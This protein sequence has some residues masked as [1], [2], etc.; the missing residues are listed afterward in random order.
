M[1]LDLQKPLRLKIRGKLVVAFAGLSILPVLIVGLLAISYNVS[2]LRRIAVENLTDDLLTIK[3]RLGAFFGEMEDNGHF[4][5]ASASFRRFLQTTARHP[6]AARSVADLELLQELRAF[7][8]RKGILYQIKFIDPTGVEV[9]NIEK[10]SGEYYV[11][12]RD[13]LNRTGTRFYLYL[14]GRIPPNRATFVPVELWNVQ[15]SSS[16]PA[17]S[18]VYPVYDPEFSGVLI[19]QIYAKRFFKI[20][21]QKTPHISAGTVMLV[22]AEGYYLYHSEK[23]KEWNHLLASKATENLKHDFGPELTNRLLNPNSALLLESSRAMI[24]HVPL[25]TTAG[26]TGSQYILLKSVPKE[27]IF[28]PV[29]KFKR[30]FWGLLGLFLLVSLA[31]AYL[32]TRQF[33]DPIQKLQREIEEVARGDFHARVDIRTHDEIQELARQFNFMAQSLEQRE[34]ELAQHRER[35]EQMVQERTR[36]LRDQKNKLQVILDNVPSGFLL[37]DRD[38]RI[39]SA[40]AA[41]SSITGTPVEDLLGRRCYEVM[42]NMETCAS[43]PSARVFESGRMET[44]LVRRIGAEGEERYLEHVAVPLKTD[45]RV[46]TVLEI[47]TDVTERKR[48]QDQLIR[49][50]RLAATGE[51]AA[52]IAHEMRNSLTSVQMIL[53]LLAETEGLE[54]S[55]RESLGVALDSIDRM[56]RV[57]DDLLQLA[58]PA[59]LDKKPANIND[60]LTDSVEFARHQVAR[61]GIELEMQFDEHVPLIPLDRDHMKEAVFN[62]LL[63]A[64]QAIRERG[65]I[66]VRSSLHTLTKQLRHLGEVG[67]AADTEGV[68]VQEIILKKGTRVLRVEV[69]DT[70]CGIPEE[71][72]ARIFDPFFT[73]KTNGTGLGLSFVKRVVN[74]HGG[75]VRVKSRV[76]KGSTFTLLLPLYDSRAGTSDRS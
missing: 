46:S 39:L 53:Q 24:A 73:T 13:E 71:H 10:R 18:C 5:T 6:S 16:L 59:P 19:L 35:L 70:G 29:T 56:E 69:A 14:A 32:A 57:V 44:Q 30:V 67:M 76:G 41:L 60:I 68:A 52:V 37:L 22:N 26:T 64:S 9:F 66:V 45:G 27:A 11:L 51:I 49:S 28:A 17:I 63:N 3:E 74:E 38:H 4:I 48:L 34:A 7:A 25:F 65:K 15:T 1:G 43:C 33:T 55:D 47:I 62:L 61:S 21:E 72:M 20:I 12:S 8:R 75:V 40:S 36:E 54:P 2:S 58:R 31:L 42:G 23:K 50:E